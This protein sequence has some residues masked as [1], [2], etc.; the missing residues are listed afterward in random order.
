MSDMNLTI[1]SEIIK[2][3]IEAKIQ[4][5]IAKELCGAEEI[6]NRMVSEV[7][8]LKVNEKGVFGSY[9]SDN[10]YP[11]LEGI[12]RAKIAESAQAAVQELVDESKPKIKAAIKRHLAKKIDGM[13]SA[14]LDSVINAT[15]LPH[16]FQVDFKVLEQ[17]PSY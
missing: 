8:K 11:L 17:K 5:A 16:K 14:F 6:I 1:N 4:S 7:L 15:T 12:C 9:S 13:A 2:P 3:I 10:K